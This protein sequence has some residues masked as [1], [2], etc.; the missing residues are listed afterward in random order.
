[1]IYLN[2]N[3]VAGFESGALHGTAVEGALGFWPWGTAKW[4]Y[5]FG[6]E[7]G[8]VVSQQGPV[9]LSDSDAQSR[10]ADIMESGLTQGRTI[11]PVRFDWDAD[12]GQWR[13]A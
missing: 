13:Q 6:M 9:W 8:R 12:A 10:E 5:Y 11:N 3:R 2:G 1:M 7:S 4:R